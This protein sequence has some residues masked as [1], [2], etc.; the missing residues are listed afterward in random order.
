MLTFAFYSNTY[1]TVVSLLILPIYVCC[2][3]CSFDSFTQRRDTGTLIVNVFHSDAIVVPCN[4]HFILVLLLLELKF[5][6]Q[7]Q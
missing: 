2:T 7:E 1:I 3:V 5:T 6:G 4:D